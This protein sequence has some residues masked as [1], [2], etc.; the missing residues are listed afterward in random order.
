MAFALFNLFEPSIV[1]NIYEFALIEPTMAH[2]LF[3]NHP[4]LPQEEFFYPT[5]YR[6]GYRWG[7]TRGNEPNGAIQEK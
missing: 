7:A 4:M 6:K 3:Q 1:K 5:T 2:V